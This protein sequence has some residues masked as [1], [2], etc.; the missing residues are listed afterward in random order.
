MRIKKI[1]QEMNNKLSGLTDKTVKKAQKYDSIKQQ[2][3]YIKFNVKNIN[4]FTNENNGTIGI[5]IEY[6]MPKIK[7]Y[8]D[9]DGN[10]LENN[11]FIA[12]NSLDLISFE[13]MEKIKTYIKNVERKINSEK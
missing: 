2:L 12:I 3:D 6:E 1:L 9:G 7:I 11:R 10:I 4:Y 5:E 13:E 8:F